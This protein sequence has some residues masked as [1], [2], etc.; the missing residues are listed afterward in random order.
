[1]AG[2]EPDQPGDLLRAAPA[3]ARLAAGAWLRTA[4]WTVTSS[5]RAGRSVLRAAVSGAPASELL[6]EAGAGLREQARRLLGVT[7][8]E[9][10][11]AAG[12]GRPAALD[13]A[14]TLRERGAALLERSADVE[15]DDGPHPSYERILAQ[16]A[17]DE[18]RILRLLATEGPQAAVD[19]RTWW[20]LDAGS[21]LVARGLSMIGAHAG[22]RHPERLPAYLDNLHR[23]G[24]VWFSREPLGDVAAYQVLEA[25]PE[26]VAAMRRCGARTRTVRR[27]VRLTP[28]GLDFCATCLPIEL[29]PDARQAHGAVPP[30]TKDVPGSRP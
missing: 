25:Q 11:V 1:V 14:A 24:L 7:D 21:S 28:F 19:I 3:L 18:A 26:V 30:A 13:G 16:L 8:I 10:R 4:E 23:L 12:N 27:S 15:A 6:E 9:R 22:C 20:P 29:P 5:L 17:P 2:R